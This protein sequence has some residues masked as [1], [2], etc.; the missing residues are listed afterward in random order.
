ML[1]E[2]CPSTSYSAAI[3]ELYEYVFQVG[4][5]PASAWFPHTFHPF[6]SPRA[7]ISRYGPG[8]HA[9]I[10]SY[11]SS[12]LRLCSRLRVSIMLT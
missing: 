11:C 7:N 6:R 1:E 2:K 8:E 3:I 9:S 5:Y 12:G 4:S 10:S